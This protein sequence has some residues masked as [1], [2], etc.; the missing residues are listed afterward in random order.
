MDG[1]RHLRSGE[2]IISHLFGAGLNPGSVAPV[3]QPAVALSSAAVCA[4]LVESV[5]RGGVRWGGDASVGLRSAP[6]RTF[7]QLHYWYCLVN[8]SDVACTLTNG[9][10]INGG[11]MS[12]TSI[13]CNYSLHRRHSV[14]RPVTRSPGDFDWHG[15]GI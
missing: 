8:Q 9:R 10:L 15:T 1:S 14:P 7:C 2:I 5:S 11:L 3:L 12:L 13:K 6:S 4:A